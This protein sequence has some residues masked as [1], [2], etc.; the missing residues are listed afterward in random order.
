MKLKIVLSAI[1]LAMFGT[2]F[3]NADP[4]PNMPTPNGYAYT[5]ISSSKQVFRGQ[6]TLYRIEFGTTNALSDYAQ[7]FDTFAA[8]NISALSQFSTATF[9]GP[10]WQFPSSSTGSAVSFYR[11]FSPYGIYI[12]SG[13]F[14]GLSNQ[15][16]DEVG[17]YYFK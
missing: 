14:I 16:G 13:L 6:G 12:S 3:V 5:V 4:I 17:V 8:P 9:V 11:D 1:A 2:A 10:Q 15:T 7:A